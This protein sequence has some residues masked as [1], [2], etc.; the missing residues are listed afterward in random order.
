M[1]KSTELYHSFD[2]FFSKIFEKT[3]A[4]ISFFV[5]CRRSPLRAVHYW[6]SLSSK[7]TRGSANGAVH[8]FS[9]GGAR[10]TLLIRPCWAAHRRS[11]PTYNCPNYPLF[12]CFNFNSSLIIKTF[13]LERSPSLGWESCD[14]LG[15]EDLNTVFSRKKENLTCWRDAFGSPGNILRRLLDAFD[16]VITH[17]RRVDSTRI[18]SQALSLISIVEPFPWPWLTC[19]CLQQKSGIRGCT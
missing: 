18:G 11:F 10:S 16:R 19:Q 5:E 14:A 8:F 12:F 2:S 17:L 15:F 7:Q 13:I 3:S 4:K 9:E 6:G 1:V